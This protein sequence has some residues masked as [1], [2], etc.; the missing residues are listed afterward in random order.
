MAGRLAKPTG[1][2]A[3][4]SA[5]ERQAER[6]QRFLDAGLQLF[7]DSPGYRATT[8]TA[9]SEAAGLSTRQFYEEFRTLEDVLAAL[10][11]QVNDWAEAASLAALA[12]A[13]GLPIAERAAATFRAYAANV[14]GDP[15]RIRITFVEIIGVSAR[16]EEQRLARRSRWVDL[17]CAEAAAA[18]E[19]G[20]AA[21]RDYRIAAAAFI[22]SVNGLLHDW[23]AGW[24]DATLDQV[25]DELV[26]VLLGIVRPADT[27]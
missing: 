4:R 11:L 5:E 27:L 13:D 14:T 23:R 3:G 20:E 18:A 16:L 21:P 9:L 15:R 2:Y 8:V 6:R 24:V 26:Q 7:G 17:I 25:V 10:H 12:A 19:R 22:G 1:R